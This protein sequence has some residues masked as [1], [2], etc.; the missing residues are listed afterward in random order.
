M[1]RS[2]KKIMVFHILCSPLLK[3]EQKCLE[4]YPQ[5]AQVLKN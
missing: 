1:D 4:L 3:F 2:S 5:K